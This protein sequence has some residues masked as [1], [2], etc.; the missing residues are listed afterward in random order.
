MKYIHKIATLFVATL[1]LTTLFTSCSSDTE[2]KS[3]GLVVTVIEPYQPPEPHWADGTI[4][5]EIG[6]F[7]TG[8]EMVDL[9]ERR[10]NFHAYGGGLRRAISKEEFP[11]SGTPKTVEITVVTLHEAGF[12][13]PVTISQIKRRLAEM[14]YRPLTLEEAVMTRIDFTDQPDLV[15]I[16]HKMTHFLAFLSEE[17]EELLGRLLK[18][19]EHPGKR[20]TLAMARESKMDKYGEGYSIAVT[21]V[22]DVTFHPDDNE[23]HGDLSQQRKQ[24]RNKGNRFACV[25]IKE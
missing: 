25:K 1:F 8:K 12:T 20:F 15:R 13:E 6:R 18:H 14:G 4:T 17:D 11:M 19:P 21:A 16:D 10:E 3:G 9:L 5:I 24:Y 7:K 22:T 2:E 23:R